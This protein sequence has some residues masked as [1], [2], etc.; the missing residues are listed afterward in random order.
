VR[1]PGGRISEEED[2]NDALGDKRQNRRMSDE[3]GA[4][5]QQHREPVVGLPELRVKDILDQ[6]PRCGNLDVPTKS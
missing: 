2:F 6:Y 5:G 3:P 4:S 1:D